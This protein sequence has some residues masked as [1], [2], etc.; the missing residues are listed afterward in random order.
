MWA[1]KE[2]EQ[3]ART[4]KRRGWAY[5]FMPN[6]AMIGEWERDKV[7]KKLLREDGEMGGEARS[8]ISGIDG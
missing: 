7:E 3:G 4:P 5:G 6:Y 8:I 1:E 2:D